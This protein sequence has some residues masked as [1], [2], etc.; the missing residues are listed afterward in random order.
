MAGGNVK[1]AFGDSGQPGNK[2]DIFGDDPLV[3][4]HMAAEAL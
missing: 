2:D 3:L 1:Q 4:P